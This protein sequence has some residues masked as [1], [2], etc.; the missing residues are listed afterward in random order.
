VNVR[1]PDP[2]EKQYALG[3]QP[4]KVYE[5][6]VQ[7]VAVIQAGDD[8][9]QGPIRLVAEYQVCTDTACLAPKRVE[10]PVAIR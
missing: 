3:D 6:D 1:Y 4:L 10:L 9:P 7:I 2:V 8:P 5:G